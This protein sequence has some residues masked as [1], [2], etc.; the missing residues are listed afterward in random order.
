MAAVTLAPG[1]AEPWIADLAA[2]VRSR[3]NS[4]RDDA[5]R[6]ILIGVVALLIVSLAVNAV[7]VV[8]AW[9]AGTLPEASTAA[10]VADGPR[11]ATRSEPL[12]HAAREGIE[13]DAYLV[14][15]TSGEPG[16]FTATTPRQEF[17]TDFAPTGLTITPTRRTAP[18]WKAQLGLARFGTHSAPALVGAAA[19]TASGGRVEYHRAG[20]I[21]W[22]VNGADGIEHGFIVDRAPP[23][24]SSA[25]RFEIEVGGDLVPV[26]VGDAEIHLVRDGAAILTYDGLKAFDA[27]GR[28]VGAAMHV[29]GTAIVIDVDADGARYPITVDP[30]LASSE[31]TFTPV[32][33]GPLP[34]SSG[35]VGTSIDID[36][37]TAVVGTHEAGPGSAFVFVRDGSGTWTTQ[38]RLTASD[39]QNGDMF[40]EVVSVDGDTVVVGA[41]GDDT[42]GGIDTGSAYVFVRD[43]SGGWSQEAKLTATDGSASDSFGSAVSASGD[44]SLIGATRA[45]VGPAADAGSAYVFARDAGTWTQQAELTALDGLAEDFFGGDVSLSGETALVAAG[46]DDSPTQPATGAA[47][48]FVSDVDGA[49]TQQAKLTASDAGL[50]DFLGSAVAVEGDLAAV[51][52]IG[53]DA[54]GLSNTGSVYVFARDGLGL[55]TQQTELFA[56]DRAA[57]DEFGISVDVSGRRI[58]V[59]A[60]RDDVGSVGDA[61]SAYV[62]ERD[63]DVWAQHAKLTAPDG[64]SSDM[65]GT[66]V[67][68]SGGT[69]VAGAQFDDTLTGVNSGSAR[70]FEVDGS[71]AWSHTET[72]LPTR[73]DSTQ[74]DNLG[75]DVVV[76]GDTAV[77]SAESDDTARGDNTGSAYVYVRD[78]SGVWSLQAKLTAADG[79]RNDGLGSSVAIDGDTVVVGA[80]Q[81]RSPSGVLGSAYVFVRDASGTWSQQAKLVA[82]D[83]A[84][85]DFFGN[86][87]SVA[88]DTALVGAWFD[89]TTNGA[90]TGSA[91]VFTRDGSGVWSQQ[92]HLVPPDAAVNDFHGSSVSLEG[93]TAVVGGPGG[94][95]ATTADT[96]SAYVFV[97]DGAGVWSQQAEL[98]A[99]DG[100]SG[101]G[102]AR[103][104]ELSG[105]TVVVGA[106]GVNG[107]FSSERGAA[108]V[109]TRGSE[110]W[111]QQ[112]KISPAS[113]SSQFGVGVAIEGDRIAVGANLETPGRVYLYERA[114][115]AWHAAGR[116]SGPSAV[117]NFGWSVGLDGDALVV[118]AGIWNTAFAFRLASDGDGDGVAD[119]ADNCPSA[120]NATQTDTDS[121]G[122]GNACDTDDDDDGHSDTTETAAGSNP[123]N[124]SST[125]ETCNGVD[126]DKDGFIDDGVTTLYF[127]DADSDTYGNPFDSVRACAQPSGYV[128]NSGDADDSDATVHPGAMELDDGKDNDQDNAVDEG[129]DADNDTYTPV[130]GGDADDQ[131]G[132]VY[133]G[134]PELC[135]GKDNDQDNTTDEGC[136]FDSDGDGIVDDQDPD[137]VGEAVAALPPS[138]IKAAGHRSAFF[139]RLETIEDLIA[140]GR[141]ADAITELKSLR[142][143]VDGCNGSTRERADKDDWIVDCA[144]QRDIRSLI[145]DLIVNLES[146]QATGA[147]ATTPR[148]WRG[149]VHAV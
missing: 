102:F 60:D 56:S 79:E 19:L 49:W 97:R 2:T 135:D 111:S 63:L 108:Y 107:T 138:S 25:L 27:T 39:G 18:S 10:P 21:E 43:G 126:D 45:D 24:T 91:Y 147:L 53:G 57:G 5:P 96:G 20:L 70:A 82:S 7:G 129:L 78:G 76:S 62:F 140:A 3:S 128:T 26:K 148:G 44:R 95:S 4:R 117:L 80:G 65:L 15:P 146:A 34:V 35:G 112:A 133:P 1:R 137:V 124:A 93:D 149:N 22:Y 14:R 37:D 120:A 99:N 61:G 13:R 69:V 81:D 36:G 52:A 66:A 86:A 88:G 46:G 59:G 121:D 42:T 77:V 145:D 67:G 6:R 40:G 115:T 104:L 83:A 139:D 51:A 119:S 58:A 9:I 101:D 38:A 11:S 68:V 47:Y 136:T 32:A 50:G 23:G 134:A 106:A 94:D 16:A 141:T 118:G 73:A 92:A 131:D 29:A 55:W 64:A 85:G 33:D 132:S 75:D 30:L 8:T 130:F 87:V 100:A 74:G 114:G 105:D 110:T 125:P 41:P 84:N 31:A 109:F 71:G 127:R 90:N 12:E 72:L 144:D 28:G 103:R 89:D 98:L 116:V 48:V 142:M 122:D 113:D 143:R 54:P 123:L 17:R